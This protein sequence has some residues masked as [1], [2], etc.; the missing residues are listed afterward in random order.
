MEPRFGQCL[1]RLP[2]GPFPGRSARLGAAVLVV[3]VV[4]AAGPGGVDRNFA[5]ARP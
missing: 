2:T 4:K 5:G 3:L 1:T